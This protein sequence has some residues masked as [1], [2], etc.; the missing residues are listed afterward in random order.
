MS[1][2]NYFGKTQVPTT[3][4]YVSKTAILLP[5]CRKCRIVKSPKTQT[6]ISILD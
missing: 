6:Q 2:F 1:L 4:C 3:N 5:K